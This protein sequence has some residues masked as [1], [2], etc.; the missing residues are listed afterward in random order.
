MKKIGI[1]LV[2]LMALPAGYLFSA[3]PP[4]FVPWPPHRPKPLLVGH[5]EGTGNFL[6]TD[7]IG[8]RT[9]EAE[10]LLDITEQDG[11]KFLGNITA[12]YMAPDN[13][14]FMFVGGNP[15]IPVAGS[16]QGDSASLTRPVS[17]VSGYGAGVNSPTCVIEIDGQC[18]V[19]KMPAEVTLTCR[20]RGIDY[21]LDVPPGGLPGY[22]GAPSVGEFTVI[23]QPLPSNVD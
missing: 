17:M 3:P 2:L 7:F 12:R 23:L 10:V 22:T 21:H 1:L 9:V 11:N 18:Q 14:N 19:K 20:W 15:Y 13:H 5:W 16:I 8:T 6:L 4:D